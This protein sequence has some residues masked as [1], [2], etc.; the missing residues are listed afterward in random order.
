MSHPPCSLGGPAEMQLLGDCDPISEAAKLHG[1]PAGFECPSSIA[2]KTLVVCTA[3]A[4][5]GPPAASN[6]GLHA[7]RGV[8]AGVPFLGGSTNG[9]PRAC[10]QA[11][12]RY[13]FALPD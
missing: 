2:G 8:L 13:P 10:L 7:S 5:C 9:A 3:S 11:C 12:R 6:L 4:Q 1:L